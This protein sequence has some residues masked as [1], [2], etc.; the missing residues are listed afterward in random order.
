[1]EVVDVRYQFRN[2]GA[3]R[4]SDTSADDNLVHEKIDVCPQSNDSLQEDLMTC[5]T[6]MLFVRFKGRV[7][8]GDGQSMAD[9]LK[10]E[11]KCRLTE[12]KFTNDDDKDKPGTYVEFFTPTAVYYPHLFTSTCR[13][14]AGTST[15]VETDI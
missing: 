1:M 12:V 6:L 13:R 5:E 9:A 4:L 14:V 2:S 10:H 11:V 7:A 3:V 8:V 15:L